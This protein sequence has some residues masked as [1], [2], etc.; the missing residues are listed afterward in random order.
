MRIG[1]TGPHPCMQEEAVGE[2]LCSAKPFIVTV[3][4]E[5]SSSAEECRPIHL[6]ENVREPKIL[7]K[8]M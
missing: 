1:I 3:S 2:S 4:D 6:E 5:S 8:M 7:Q